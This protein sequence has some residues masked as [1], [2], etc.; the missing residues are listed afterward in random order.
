M[1]TGDYPV[2]LLSLLITLSLTV[3]RIWEWLA[4]LITSARGLQSNLDDERPPN[5]ISSPLTN[6]KSSYDVVVIGSGYGGGGAA[7]RMSRAQPKQSVCVLE[8]GSERWP[9]QSDAQPGGFSRSFLQALIEFRV[10]GL[11]F[12]SCGIWPLNIG[13]PD[14]LY[15]WVY[16]KGSS[17]FMGQGQYI[18]TCFSSVALQYLMPLYRSRWHQ[19]NQC[20]RFHETRHESV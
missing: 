2:I 8:A 20:E 18:S 4:L 3:L 7:S 16:G 6:L 9:T 11:H 15:R 12:G 19:L 17:A 14:G 10:T 1:A 13:K 5:K